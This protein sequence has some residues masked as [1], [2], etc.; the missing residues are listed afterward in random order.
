[1]TNQIKMVISISIIL[2]Y[3]L[4]KLIESKCTMVINELNIDTP[5]VADNDEFLELK[6]YRWRGAGYLY[7]S[8]E[9]WGI[10]LYIGGE[11]GGYLYT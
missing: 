6:L 8:V 9:R 7:T 1:M 5:R 2:F 10:P 11:V 3:A 4:F